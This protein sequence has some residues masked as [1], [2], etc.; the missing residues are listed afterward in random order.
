MNQRHYEG[1]YDHSLLV[2]IEIATITTYYCS[3]YWPLVSSPLNNRLDFWFNHHDTCITIMLPLY[4]QVI[5]T[6][7]TI[8]NQ[9]QSLKPYNHQ[10][11]CDLLLWCRPSLSFHHDPDSLV[12]TTMTYDIVVI[13]VVSFYQSLIWSCLT[14][15]NHKILEICIFVIPIMSMSKRKWWGMFN[16]KAGKYG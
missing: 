11:I 1:Y 3:S 16:P 7:S 15:I 14:N 13:A 12:I 6:M 2:V 9:Y 4:H 5:P 10:W 8:V